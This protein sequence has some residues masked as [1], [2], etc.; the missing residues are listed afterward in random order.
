MPTASGR[1]HGTKI[2]AE[3]QSSV[4]CPLNEILIFV[5]ISRKLAKIDCRALEPMWKGCGACLFYY[6]RA[7]FFVSHTFDVPDVRGSKCVLT[8]L[9]WNG[10]S[11]PLIDGEN[12]HAQIRKDLAGMRNI[13]KTKPNNIGGG[14]KSVLALIS[15]RH[16]WKKSSWDADFALEDHVQVCMNI[17]SPSVPLSKYTV[18]RGD[19]KQ[20]LCYV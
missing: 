11:N 8:L 1:R 16:E 10:I 14:G 18:L 4:W 5:V 9:F 7:S 2:S 15:N 3:S 19:K 6:S 13:D 20:R 17:V 12:Y